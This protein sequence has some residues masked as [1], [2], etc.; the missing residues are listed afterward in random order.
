MLSFQNGHSMIESCQITIDDKDIR[1][2]SFVK[3]TLVDVYGDRVIVENH[4]IGYEI[5]IPAKGSLPLIGQ[6]IT[7]YTYLYVR[8][9]AMM[10]YGF[11]S[12]DA[13]EIF[14]LLITVSG[15]GPKGALGILSVLSPGELRLAVSMEDHKA[16]SQAPGVGL[17]TAKKMIIELKDKLKE[18]PTENMYEYHDTSAPAGDDKLLSMQKEA[19]EA[20]CALGYGKSEASEAA[21]KAAADLKDTEADVEKILSRSLTY[22]L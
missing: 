12:K 13:L 3:G 7:L 17:K 19:A 1:M 22:L 5:F 2:I 15:I 20:L 4:G 6:D 10:L 21:R 11:L 18:Q 8:E 16:I 14:K 9:D